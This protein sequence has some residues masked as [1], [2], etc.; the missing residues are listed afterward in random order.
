[1]K[2]EKPKMR[3]LINVQQLGIGINPDYEGVVVLLNPEGPDVMLFTLTPEA[4]NK[5]SEALHEYATKLL[6]EGKSKKQGPR[7]AESR[8]ITIFRE[9]G[10]K[11][12][13]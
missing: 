10:E 8:S 3:R 2:E 7:L 12:D 9:R 11:L 1:V 6:Q 4:A 5:A 13:S